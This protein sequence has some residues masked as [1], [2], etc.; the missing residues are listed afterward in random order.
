M[1]SMVEGRAVR[2]TRPASP[3]PLAG[4][5]RGGPCPTGSL[6][7]AYER[8]FARLDATLKRRGAGWDDV[9][10]FDTRHAGTNMAKQ[11]DALVP[12][13]NR[14][15]TAPLPAWT[16]VGV[17][18]LYELSAVMEIRLTARKVG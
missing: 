10:V 16:A 8:A 15:I 13:K 7:L 11:L 18:E 9:L 5:V 4:G 3:L 6:A 14:Y 12:V 2:G 17:T 1:R